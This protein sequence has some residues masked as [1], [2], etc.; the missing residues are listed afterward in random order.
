VSVNAT[1]YPAVITTEA[2]VIAPG[3]GDAVYPNV[4]GIEAATC[5]G[6][7]LNLG[8]NATVVNCECSPGVVYPDILGQQ[9]YC[10]PP[11]I[12]LDAE[13]MSMLV[14]LLSTQVLPSV[15]E[16]ELG[17]ATN[18]QF[19]MVSED[20][21]TNNVGA[22]CGVLDPIVKIDYPELVETDAILEEILETDA[23]IE[24][25]IHIPI[26]INRNIELDLEVTTE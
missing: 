16:P 15:L 2:K 5:D 18:Y 12:Q 26:T 19:V 14:S 1:A 6:V 8:V 10:F 21:P 7:T 11:R 22:E 23:H 3:Y 17:P 20:A 24:D 25:T 4:V 13:A 9:T